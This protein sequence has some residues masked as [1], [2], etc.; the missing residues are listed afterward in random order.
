MVSLMCA[1][2]VGEWTIGAS[3]VVWVMALQEG[4]WGRLLWWRAAVVAAAGANS[5]SSSIVATVRP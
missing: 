1:K 3:G 4:G 2:S 5:G